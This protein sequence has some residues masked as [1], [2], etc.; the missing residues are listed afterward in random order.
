MDQQ[1]L[2]SGVATVV[3]GALAGGITNA[4]AIYML[5]H[6][7]E[8]RRLGGFRLQGAIPKNRARLARSIGKTV[9][10]RLLTPE[11]LAQRLSAP[12]VREAF[13]GAMHRLVDDLLEREHGPLAEA[14][15]ASLRPVADDLVREL[16]EKVAARLAAFAAT[17]EFTAFVASWLERLRTETGDRP[18]GALLTPAVRRTVSARVD[19]W[20]AHLAEGDELEATL[21]TW[22]EGQLAQLERDPRPVADRL[23]AS[24]LAPLEQ[25]IEDYLPTA[26]DRVA[27]MLADPE[28]RA[29][30]S[31]ALRTAFDGA[32]RQLLLHERIL[33]KLVVKDSTF[34]R[35]LDG[36]ETQGYERFAAAITAPAVRGRLAQAIHQAF[37]G[38]LRLP[39]GERLR[40]LA[41]EQRQ[42]LDRTV[43]DWVVEAVRSPGTRTAAL[44]LVDRGLAAAADRT[45]GEVLALIPPDQAAAMAG[46]GLRSEAGQAWVAATVARAVERLMAQPIGRPATWLGPDTAAALRQG[47]A[48]TAWG[49]VQA[50]VPAVVERI[51]VPE[52]VEQKVLGFSTQRMEEIVRTVT[53]RELDVIVRLGYLIG[54]M[55]GLIAVLVNRVL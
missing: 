44:H 33:A 13:D 20:A 1:A 45:W 36:L 54:G 50:Q 25:A 12:Q 46:E 22:A 35:L 42:A 23:P 28:T 51:R 37:L 3:V 55:V 38:L 11:D 41:P 29:T 53:Q 10:E 24:L 43:G 21:R 17:P 39:L 32:A 7:H 15:P 4:I 30:V 49:F 47:I 19:Q 14:L 27:A 48:H 8:E 2:L 34:E 18:L 5:F 40:R 52:M 16:G 26:I 6:P 9:G 31:G